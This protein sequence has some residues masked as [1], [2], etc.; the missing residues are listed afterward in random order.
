MS[1]IRKS[2]EPNRNVFADAILG[3]KSVNCSGRQI[4]QPHAGLLGG[5]VSD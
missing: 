1:T 3:K 4:G 5:G 2:P